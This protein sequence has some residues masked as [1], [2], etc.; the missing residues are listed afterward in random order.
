[1]V[2]S[3]CYCIYFLR[4][5]VEVSHVPWNLH[6]SLVF[7][8]GIYCIIESILA[9]RVFDGALMTFG[10]FRLDSNRRCQMDF[11]RPLLHKLLQLSKV[12]CESE[13]DHIE[14]A[15]GNFVLRALFHAKRCNAE[16]M[17]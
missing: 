6:F 3:S 11:D 9:K 16:S 8:F 12:L 17:N 14:P 10:C 7:T 15:R 5:A 2:S 13:L 1:M 4:V